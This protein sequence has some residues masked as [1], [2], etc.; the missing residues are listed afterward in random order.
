M[1]KF[2]KGHPKKGGR[3]KGTPNKITEDVSAL[4][5]QL[6]SEGLSCDPIELLARVVGNDHAFFDRKSSF[7]INQRMKAAVELAPYR[8]PKR[9]A[10]EVTTTGG[11]APV[12]I[13]PEKALGS[14][15]AEKAQAIREDQQQVLQ[16]RLGK[17]P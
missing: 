10:I 7:T 4:L 12:I 3:K 15:W 9:K 5:N 11:A 13:V 16:E 6:Q 14:T 8:A 1:G 17:A 2:E